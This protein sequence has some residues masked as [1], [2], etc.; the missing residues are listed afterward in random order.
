MSALK[1]SRVSEQNRRVEEFSESDAQLMP[2][3][4]VFQMPPP[5]VASRTLALL[6]GS[7]MIAEIRAGRAGLPIADQLLAVCAAS[8]LIAAK[9]RNNKPD[10]K[11]NWWQRSP[12]L[13]WLKVTRATLILKTTR[14][15]PS[16][17]AESEA[18]LID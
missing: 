13:S 10:V 12:R 3:S 14:E 5:G 4:S 16:G 17:L 9:K 8:L 15:Q 6:R 11:N 7:E 1:G 18:P 2:S